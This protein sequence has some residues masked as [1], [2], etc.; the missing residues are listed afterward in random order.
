MPAAAQQVFITNANTKTITI[1][2]TTSAGYPGSLSMN[3]LTLSAPGSDSN[4]LLLDNSGWA[5][6]LSVAGTFSIGSGGA[7]VVNNG[8]VSAGGGGL[9]SDGNVFLNAGYLT[10]YNCVIGNTASGIGMVVTNGSQGHDGWGLYLGNG[11]G[12]NSNTVLI[13]GLNSAWYSG[14]TVVIGQSGN[15]NQLTI[16]NGGQLQ[17]AFSYIGCADSASNNTVLVTDAGSILSNSAELYV[18][19]YGSGNQLLISNGA[20]VVSSAGYV[21]TGSNANNNLVV[22]DGAASSWRMAGS[23]IVATNGLGNSMT[24]ADGGQVVASNFVLSTGPGANWG[25]A[26]VQ[27]GGRLIAT[28][29]TSLIA[30]TGYAYGT[31]SITDG[32]YVQLGNVIVGDETS[33]NGNISINNS[34]NEILGNLTVGNNIQGAGSGGV[35]LNGGLLLV[36]N[37]LTI[38]GNSG[39]GRLSI[40]DGIWLARE[41]H[42]GEQQTLGQ[43]PSLYI[44]G[45]QSQISGALIMGNGSNTYATG[46][47]NGGS[48]SAASET[49]G[50]FGGVSF[51]QGD[52]TNAIGGDLVLGAQ[53][54]SF[55]NFELDGGSL[56]ASNEYIGSAGNAAFIQWGGTN[57]VSGVLQIGAATGNTAFYSLF[58]GKLTVTNA[59]ATIDIR[60]TGI[61]TNYGGNVDCIVV[62][63][64]SFVHQGGPFNAQL[65]NQGSFTMTADFAPSEGVINYTSIMIPT[66]LTLSANGSGFDNEGTLA[67]AGGTLAG[68][69]S[70]VNT[71]IVSGYGAINN[72]IS[73][74]GVIEATNGTLTLAGAVANNPGGT[75]QA[76]NGSTL[77]LTAG[78]SGNA[79]VINLYGGTLDNTGHTLT[80]AN[81]IAGNGTIIGSVVNDATIAPGHSPGTLNITGDLTLGTNSVLTM[82]L[83]GNTTN[84]YDR[85]LVSGAL[86]LDGSLQ[87]LTINSFT[88]TAGDIFELFDFTSED[89]NF[90]TTNLPALGTGL[91]WD[92]SQLDN[93]GVLSIVAIPEPTS[94]SLALLAM[95]GLYLR[96]KRR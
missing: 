77:A 84:L 36:T 76:D 7:L 48:L 24:I 90:S 68:S 67:L 55:G 30:G 49:L 42:V 81:L 1:D 32:G 11:L 80:N 94:W 92:T 34:T 17:S 96:R 50:N 37:G 57:T 73:N 53:A 9:L 35:S 12:A 95:G 14:Y 62:N 88:P 58:G 10:A 18:G 85:I 5:T 40:S 65:I 41:V 72:Q 21:G 66:N 13:S 15:A 8:A 71:G 45:G 33:G 27:T 91:A 70:L 3:S 86:H 69:G 74:A 28:N 59:G 52:G 26:A 87:V 4:T 47:Q 25:Y 39:C 23:L 79:G 78:L 51:T 19:Q 89:G 82:E 64:G 29:G 6:P 38:I 44:S 83:A 16:S 22:V 31:L 43:P 75:L 93:S 60:P 56:L 63:E 54:G 20:Q 61:F 46:R 2:A